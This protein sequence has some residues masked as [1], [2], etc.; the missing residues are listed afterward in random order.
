MNKANELGSE[1]YD[2]G[3]RRNGLGI[4]G[5]LGAGRIGGVR[6]NGGAGWRG[7]AWLGCWFRF[8]WWVSLGRGLLVGEFYFIT[9][10]FNFVFF[11]ILLS[12]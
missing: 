5:M 8:R 1:V 6:W 4:G 10:L 12:Y 3:I 2:L 7:W 11:I 9:Y